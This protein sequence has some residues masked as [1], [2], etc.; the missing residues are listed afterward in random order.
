MDC[1]PARCGHSSGQIRHRVHLVAQYS[2]DPQSAEFAF[3][4][5][6]SSASLVRHR[7]RCA[8]VSAVDPFTATTVSPSRRPSRPRERSWLRSQVP[9]V[10]I[11]RRPTR[12][13]ARFSALRCAPL[14]SFVRDGCCSDFLSE[15]GSVSSSRA[16]W[17]FVRSQCLRT[18]KA[19][20][21]SNECPSYCTG[22]LRLGEA[23][24]VPDARDR[25]QSAGTMALP[26]TRHR[27]AFSTIR[28]QHVSGARPPSSKRSRDS[29]RCRTRLRAA[30]AERTK[31]NRVAWGRV[32][33]SCPNG[34]ARCYR[35]SSRQFPTRHEGR[36]VVRGHA[37]HAPTGQ[38][39]VP[40]LLA[41]SSFG[42]SDA[43]HDATLT[44]DMKRAAS[45]IRA[46]GAA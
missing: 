13:Y 21:S 16:V 25:R 9:T 44:L 22:R 32:L 10:A 46:A 1:C 29:S 17:M 7:R 41:Q 36:P 37:T 3:D 30:R 19:S 45:A 4:A 20:Q 15:A 38:R 24:R 8:T 40:T 42:S 39:A 28:H 27:C 14:A 11:A 5:P 12:G 35:S 34:T 6:V 31:C 2:C 23:D 33:A 43:S 26:V 18:R